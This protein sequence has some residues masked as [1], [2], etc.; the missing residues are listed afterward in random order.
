MSPSL[1]DE[2]HT[3][4]TLSCRRSTARDGG[5]VGVN[6]LL[7]FTT[8]DGDSP[9]AGGVAREGGGVTLDAAA[10][11]TDMMGL[12]Q[13]VVVT[14]VVVI[15]V[16]AADVV[17]VAA[18]DAG[19]A[20]SPGDDS[21]EGG[22][23]GG[24]VWQATVLFRGSPPVAHDVGWPRFLSVASGEVWGTPDSFRRPRDASPIVGL[25]GGVRCFAPLFA[26]GAPTARPRTDGVADVPSSLLLRVAPVPPPLVVPPA[27]RVDGGLSGATR[28]G[29]AAAG[30]CCDTRRIALVDG[31]GVR[32]G[33]RRL[34]TPC[35]DD[36]GGVGRGGRRSDSSGCLEEA[37]LPGG[38]GSL[39][40]ATTPSFVLLDVVAL[41]AAV[42][43]APAVRGLTAVGCGGGA[44][45]TAA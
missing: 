26:T 25:A 42:P 34:S 30:G 12:P 22:A 38:V 27:A 33:V 39:A 21:G 1:S 5:W 10:N 19:P 7:A 24:G 16:I 3:T 15:V 44:A 20:A 11:P 23:S 13:T 17:V 32:S 29:F 40:A 8:T 14:V 31:D 36:D 28:A 9:M 6:D 43:R 2:R 35:S 4:S 45:V 18:G 37:S 41:P